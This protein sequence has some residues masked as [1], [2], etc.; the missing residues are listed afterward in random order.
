MKKSDQEKLA[1]LILKTKGMLATNI[2]QKMT[3]DK[4]GNIADFSGI[5]F[6]KWANAI[7]TPK[8]VIGILNLLSSLNDQQIIQLM[9][10]WRDDDKSLPCSPTD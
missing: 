8:S 6:H 10:M 5:N 2:I 9:D 3:Y 1:S 4:M 7:N